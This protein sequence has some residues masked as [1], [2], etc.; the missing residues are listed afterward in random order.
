MKFLIKFNSKSIVA[1]DPMDV[2]EVL[3]TNV[4]KKDIVKVDEGT[5]CK[6]AD[7]QGWCELATAGDEYVGDDFDIEAVYKFN[8]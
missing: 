8:I 4:Y 6:A 2:Y 5:H 1:T 3:V 7:A